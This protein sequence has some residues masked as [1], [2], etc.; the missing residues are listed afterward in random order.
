MKN[1]MK[2]ILIG[3]VLA[4][5]F[6]AHAQTLDTIKQTGVVKIGVR[7]NAAPLSSMTKDGVASG[8][9]VDLCQMVVSDMQSKLNMKLDI[10]YVPVTAAEVS[11]K[12]NNGDIN[13]ECGVTAVNPLQRSKM[14]VSYNTFVTSTNLVTLSKNRAYRHRDF[15]SHL[16]AQNKKVAIMKDSGQDA[17]LNKWLSV[18]SLNFVTVNSVEEGIQKVASGEAFAFMQEKV[19][20]EKAIQDLKLN[21]D[22]FVFAFDSISVAPYSI[23]LKKDDDKMLAM[24]DS[25]LK[26]VY[27]SGAARKQMEAVLLTQGYS[28]NNLS[29]DAMR[30]PSTENAVN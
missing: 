27:A 25:S 15:F 24:V 21:K 18:K 9:M 20:G 30:A 10:Q 3:A 23:M 12:V 11:D 28:I 13:M 17:V 5:G 16:V 2:S 26:K 19:V 4:I 7:E 29:Y 22:D 14:N 6:G 1:A 8:Y